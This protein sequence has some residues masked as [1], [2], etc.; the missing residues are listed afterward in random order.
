MLSVGKPLLLALTLI[1]Y[2]FYDGYA[3]I[4]GIAEAALR[5]S[6]LSSAKSF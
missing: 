5:E 2:S 1:S 6:E 3:A 4:I